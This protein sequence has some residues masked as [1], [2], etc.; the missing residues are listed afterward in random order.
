MRMTERR[1]VRVGMSGVG[2]DESAAASP[3]DVAGTG[4]CRACGSADQPGAICT[5]C[6]VSLLPWPGSVSRI[7][8][9]YELAGKLKVTRRAAICTDEGG[10]EVTLHV[11]PKHSALAVQVDELPE[12]SAMVD[13]R[14]SPAARL[15][16]AATDASGSSKW[17]RALLQQRA[18]HMGHRSL[19]EARQFANEALLLGWPEV[20]AGLPLTPSEKAWRRAHDAACDGR[21]D[22]LRAVLLELPPSGYHQ[23]S[24]LL[25]PYL[26]ALRSDPEAWQPLI[27]PWVDAGLPQSDVLASVVT[28]EWDEAS[29][30]LAPLLSQERRG[31]W[32]E[33]F[34]DLS[35]IPRLAPIVAS[36]GWWQAAS[37]FGRG[38]A[39]ENVD[40]LFG[41][42]SNLDLELLDD[43]IDAGALVSPDVEVVNTSKHAA[44]L[45]A[46]VDPGSMTDG[47]VT[48]V[49]HTSESLRRAFLRRDRKALDE[50]ADTPS[51]R[52][53]LALA[54]SLD[55]R[56][57]AVDD[58]TEDA[59]RT[60]GLVDR[61][62][63]ALLDGSTTEVAAPILRDPTLW[64]RFEDLAQNGKLSPTP[65]T[66]EEHPSFS[67]WCD[68]QRLMGLLWEERWADAARLGSRLA[69]SLSDEQLQDEALN[70]AA[71]AL[72]QQHQSEDGLKLLERALDGSYTESLL[73]NTSLLAAEVD[74]DLAARHLA[75]V[76]DE[77]PTA[78]LRAAAL[79]R[80]VAVWGEAPDQETFPPV[81]VKALDRV[82]RAGCSF[83]DYVVFMSL[84]ARVAPKLAL[85]LPTPDP[86]RRGVHRLLRAQARFKIED[87]FGFLD[88]ADEF[89]AV[90]KESGRTEWFDDEWVPFSAFLRESVFV[91][92]GK[93]LGSASVI[94]RV[95][96]AAPELFSTRERMVLLG[97]A[98]AHFAA[99]FAEDGS[100][101]N[102]QAFQKFFFTPIEGFLAERHLLEPGESEYVAQN[103][104]R[105]L[106]IAGLWLLSVGRD[107]IADPYNTLV[108]RLRWDTQNRPAIRRQMSALLDSA[109]TTQ[110]LGDRVHDRLMRLEVD[111]E[112]GRM[113]TET[114]R[115]T[116]HEWRTETV[117][118]RSQL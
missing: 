55:G 2:A 49:V 46:R 98:G 36:P 96:L 79:R 50:L 68:L 24:Q 74:P 14:L 64:G 116:V 63:A 6:G 18:T 33:V 58:L 91:E 86:D 37:V 77:A 113:R 75:R 82:V 25:M 17:D 81:L 104:H 38:S 76:V 94:D 27:Q 100:T 30:M 102:E 11:S 97:Q 88:L 80:A 1:S 10:A 118:L 35:D 67:C 60:L 99:A 103:F 15:Q 87:E 109:S 84:A 41:V 73:I 101:L 93:A 34:D 19:E 106:F 13:S 4:W 78:E 23:R 90:Y 65:D 5:S 89:V 40:S 110:T 62:R 26:G 12:P 69:D 22:E 28:G 70:L 107:D 7:G 85:D 59:Q 43:L 29:S 54:D 57:F 51:G 52:H 92:F 61:S 48:E 44:F 8:L 9:T 21:L 20:L 83:E 117:Q 105:T 39:G 45:L 32:S 95:C 53:Y 3:S 114:I 72:S 16:F 108:Q 112:D 47:Q 71:Y 42:V 56:P 115:S 66:R 31:V 111:D